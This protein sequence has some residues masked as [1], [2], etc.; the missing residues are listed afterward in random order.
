MIY[1]AWHNTTLHDDAFEKTHTHV[2]FAA[3]LVTSQATLPVD[4]HLNHV[5]CKSDLAAISDL[6]SDAHTLAYDACGINRR[7]ST[8]HD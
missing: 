7:F 4:E 2:C 6:R 1:H 8:M 5:T 3:V